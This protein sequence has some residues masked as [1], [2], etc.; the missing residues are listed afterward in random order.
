[1]DLRELLCNGEEVKL[2]PKV[3]DLLVYL[4]ENRERPVNKD[5]LQDAVWPGMFITETALTRAVMKARKAVGDDAGKQEVIKTLH[6]HGYRFIAEIGDQGENQTLQTGDVTQESLSTSEQTAQ[7]TQR[8]ISKSLVWAGASILILVLASTWIFTRTPQSLTADTRIAVLP[9]FNDTGNTELDWTRLGLMSFVSGMLDTDGQLSVV[10]DADVFG[11]ADR[12]EWDGSLESQDNSELLEKLHSIYGASHILAM[13][14]SNSGQTLRMN[15]GLLSS[16]GKLSEGTMVGEKGTGLAQGVVQSIYGEFLGRM[17]PDANVEAV[18]DDPFINEA[19]ARGM[20]LSREG[21]CEDAN[22]LFRVI[23]D[24]EADLFLPRFELAKCLRVLGEWEEAEELLEACITDQKA[25]EPGR[26]LGLSYEGMG[27]LYNRTGRLAEAESIY[28][29]AL[30]VALS[31][32][33]HELRAEVLNQ[34]AILADD[35][36]KFDEANDLINRSMLA[37]REAGREMVPGQLWSAKANLNMS[38]GELNQADDD[39]AKALDAYRRIGDRR[40]E[41]MMINNTGFLRRLQGRLDEA[42][43]FHLQSLAI[44]EEIGDRVGVGRIHNFLAIIYSSRGEYDRARSSTMKSLEVATETRDRLF[45]A[46][47]LTRLADIDYNQELIESSRQHFLEAQA[48]F[49]EIEDEMRVL[50]VGV[51]LAMLELNS[52]NFAKAEEIA[53]EVLQRAKRKELMQPE[54]DAMEMMADVAKARGDYPIAVSRYG[55]TLDRVRET[56]WTAKESRILQKLANTFLDVNDLDSA[57]PLV[58][59]LTIMEPTAS[60]LKTRARFEY[61]RGDNLAAVELMQS[62]RVEAGATWD[63]DDEGTLKSYQSESGDM[64]PTE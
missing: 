3:F 18:S 44:R 39:L 46:T 19:F 54:V 62:A 57:E 40:R 29:L 56:S 21:L 10:P 48:I 47:A 4:V 8:G 17:R 58:G 32:N 5:E 64:E 55:E 24:Q 30:E 26:Y 28:Q 7:P 53:A 41:A 13:T 16:A 52:E 60:I 34:M 14:L 12:L 31:I 61:L 63:D 43:S 38:R 6:G 50:Q 9:L 59:A 35:R 22:K 11:L 2:Q 20:S 23:T 37:Y 45:E 27:V 36:G 49:E 33:D 42:E 25:K 51:R 15:Y 1:V